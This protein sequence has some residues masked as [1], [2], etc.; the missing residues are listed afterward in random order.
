[1]KSK[2][3][4]V[5]R[6]ESTAVRV[7]AA[8]REWV[9]YRPADLESLWNSIGKDNSRDADDFME[10][11]RLPYWVELWPSSVTLAGWLWDKRESL[12]GRRCLDV[13]CGLGLT[14]LVASH[15]GATV[16]ALDYEEDALRYAALN[17]QANNVPQPLWVVMDWRG[18]AVAAHAFDRIWGGDIMYERRFVTPVLDFLKYALA[19]G[20]RVWLAEP[21]RS[22]YEA[23]QTALPRRGWVARLVLSHA[24]DPL[25]IQPSKV[26]V[27]LWELIRESA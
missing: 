23:F 4:P 2:R 6:N 25:N 15:S 3:S 10:D 7:T 17:A 1:M 26:S 27:R 11:E 14:A 18:P 8:G 22:V 19:P 24:E 12:A 5:D 16:C 9:L 21:S 20:G 13:G